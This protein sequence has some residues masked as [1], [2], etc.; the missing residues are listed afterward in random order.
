MTICSF[1]ERLTEEFG[2]PVQCQRLW[3]WTR[4][5][6]NTYRVDRPLTTEEEKIPVSTLPRC[7]TSDHLELFLEVVHTLAIPKWLNRDDYLV[8]L[9]LYDPEK[10]RLRYVGTMYVKDSWTVS[11][12]LQTL[13]NLAGCV[14]G[15]IEL[16]K[17][18]TG[19]IICYQKILK[20]QDLPKYH[21]VA[22]FLQHICDQKVA[23]EEMKRQILEEKIAGLEHQASADRLEKV[24][25]LIAYDQMKHERD[26]AVRQVNE[27]RDQ[28][29]HA[30]LK[31]SRCDLEQATEH[32]TDAC[33][34]GDTEYGRTYKA[35]M[36]GTE[37]AIKLSST[38]SLFQQEVTVLG[39]CRHP[40]IITFIGVCSKISAL[41]YEWLPNG[42]NLED[43]IVCANNSTPLPWQN[44]TQIIGEICC[45]LLFLHSNN[46]NPP[47]AALI[48]GD[49]RPCNI[50]IDD[51]ASYR[52]RLCNVG[53][54]S[55]FLQPG[56]CPPNLMERLSYMDPEF[57]TTG[58]LTT[59]SDV[60]SFGVIILRLLTG[61][62]PLNLSKKVAAELESDNLHRLIDKSAGD[63]PYKEAKQLAVLGVRCAEMAREKRPDLL[64][65]V[66]RVVRPL[67]RKPSSCPYFPPASPEVC[68]PAPFIC[69]ILMEIMKDPQV[70]SDGFTY[71][72]EA[73]RR[74]FDSGNNRSPMTNLVLPDLKLIPNRVLRSSIHEYLR[75]QKQQQQQEEGSVT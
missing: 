7:S 27:L 15:R 3:W 31:F 1:K 40:N 35:I 45:A 43:H 47:T 26:N 37:V 25:T 57:I 9:K 16:Y 4:R 14:S 58:E 49:L 59:L 50:L 12:V 70:A 44:R 66:W 65:D 71:E 75:Q 19:D 38:E 20:T 51:D 68:I 64:N 24:E 11:H 36:H 21:S 53:L 22:S 17:I 23:E 2:T 28:S 29:T 72:G 73:I 41:V 46:K 48:H 54:S 13:R 62:A 69:P 60:Y 39:Q 10:A 61:M 34:V 52:S 55:L 74:W 30:I 42:R 63:W 32:F 6:N 56:T 67:M 18:V 5:Q 33:K 8:F